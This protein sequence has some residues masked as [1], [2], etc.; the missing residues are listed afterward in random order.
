MRT[1][2]RIREAQVRVIANDGSQ[3]GIMP[4]DQALV[5]ARQEGLDLV[6]I[7]P[8]ATPP[9][10]KI[11][12]FGKYKYE[13]AKKERVA[14]RKQ[15]VTVLKGIRLTPSTDEHDLMTKVKMARKFIEEGAKVKASIVFRGRMI[16]HQE[17][18]TRMLDRLATELADV[19]KLE[20]P[21]KMEGP[22]MMTMIL[23]KK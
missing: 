1:N 3:L 7:A 6:E 17:F 22:R 2:E 23:I 10:V 11:M 19:A 12:D 8:L 18:G 15:Q 21:P 14:R 9:V 13:L 20:M 16:T 5:L 4:A